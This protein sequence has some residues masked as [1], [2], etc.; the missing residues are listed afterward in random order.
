M[1]RTYY[2]TEIQNFLSHKPEAVLGQLAI[3]HQ[4][5]LK[6]SQKNAWLSQIDILQLNLRAYTD[7]YIFFEYSIPRMG[8]RVDNILVIRGVIFVIEFKVGG[9][10][11]D[12]HALDQVVDYALD[13]KNFHLQSHHRSIVP[14]LVAT[15]ADESLTPVEAYEDLVYKPLRANKHY[16]GDI[17]NSVLCSITATSIDPVEWENS[18]Y[19]PTP[20]IIEAAQALYRGHDV[21]EISRS[22]SGA[23]N[24]TET[25]NAIIQIIDESKRRGQKSICFVSGVPGSGKTLA[26]LYIANA[27]LG[28]GEDEHAVLLSGNGPLVDVLREALARNDAELSGI[29]K[30]VALSKVRAFVQNIHHFRDDALN[31]ENAPI[32]KVVIFDEAQRA[33]TLKQTASFM[34]RKRGVIGFDMSE[35]AFLIG[36]MDRHSDWAVIVCLIA[37]GQEINTGEA[38][39]PEWFAAVKAYYPHW[40]V[41]TSDKLSDFEYTRGNDLA[42]LV[43][44]RQ[45]TIN[46]ALHLAVSIRSY[47]SENVS[48]L[49]KALLDDNIEAAKDLWTAVA[50][51]FPIALTRDIDRA[52]RWLKTRAR[53]TERYGLLASSAGGRL[54]P[55]GIDAHAEI[56]VVNWLLNDKDDVRSSYYL[57]DVATEFSIQGLELDWACVA[58]DADLRHMALGWEY[59]SF[60]GAEWNNVN[61]SIRIL[62]LKNAY[63]VL[64][65]RA[66]Q[67][68]VIF[69]PHGSPEDHTR[70]PEFYD[71][72]FEYLKQ[73]GIECI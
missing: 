48:A 29:K 1:S 14:I 64:L 9:T 52:K 20:T 8:K 59:K 56:D 66:R 2:S 24:L 4:F 36:V 69:V 45:L 61:D 39:L 54:K 10:T 7:G 50:G 16:L 35:P 53:G 15:E 46:P 49:V 37:G 57:E 13:L 55:F 70:K 3:H 23:I 27:R 31:S 41:Y 17:I 40:A 26:G 6:E 68:M 25:T 67:G 33:W 44:S 18:P 72:T 65:T 12:S 62:Y 58:W 32:E 71:G 51:R 63:R 73:I 22:D 38:G 21:T 30:G 60:R 34:Q 42:A 28:F 5:A 43:D 19:K 47:R 11:Y